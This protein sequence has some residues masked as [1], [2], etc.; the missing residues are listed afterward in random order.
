MGDHFAR[1]DHLDGQM[2]CLEVFIYIYIYIYICIYIYLRVYFYVSV[3][4]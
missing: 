2:R 1:L 4:I 3:Y